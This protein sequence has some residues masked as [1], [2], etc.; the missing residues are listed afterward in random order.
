M[1]STGVWV[2]STA[3]CSGVVA[4]VL[5]ASWLGVYQG[6]P[7]DD[8]LTRVFSDHFDFVRLFV[9]ALT[10]GV[11][12]YLTG[13]TVASFTTGGAGMA[14]LV[15]ALAWIWGTA[16]IGIPVGGALAD[17][18]APRR[19]PS[20]ALQAAPFGGLLDALGSDLDFYFHRERYRAFGAFF[21]ALAGYG[22]FWLG[23][24]VAASRAALANENE[25]LR[26]ENAAL[27]Q[28]TR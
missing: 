17:W 1:A 15:L 27:R 21:G 12:G 22:L 18:T 23:S 24:G 7:Q 25:R 8:F 26:A 3:C 16:F 11:L 20:P 14:Y 9:A 19:A 28:D 6:P 4:G 5:T 2:K 10:G 13:C